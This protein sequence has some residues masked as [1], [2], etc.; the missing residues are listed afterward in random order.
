MSWPACPITVLSAGNHSERQTTQL[1]AGWRTTPS[2]LFLPEKHAL[3]ILFSPVSH[4]VLHNPSLKQQIPRSAAGTLQLLNRVLALLLFC[5][6]GSRCWLV[7]D[8]QDFI[9]FCSRAP[10]TTVGSA[11]PY[12]ARELSRRP[13][14]KEASLSTSRTRSHRTWRLLW[15][16]RSKSIEW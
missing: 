14:L 11:L 4:I 12:S 5:A 9:L 8:S 10:R 7:L 13:P 16:T 2:P 3:T 15:A 6:R 1:I